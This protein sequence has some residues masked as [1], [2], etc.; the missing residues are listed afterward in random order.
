ME[1]RILMTAAEMNLF[2]LLKKKPLSAEDIAS[3]T[4]SNL[5][6]LTMVLDALAAMELLAKQDGIYRCTDSTAQL[7]SDDA[8]ASVLPM[9][10]HMASLWHRWSHLKRRN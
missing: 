5:R 3:S 9:V 10:R 7:L 6:A 1:C 8:P 2:S 4:G